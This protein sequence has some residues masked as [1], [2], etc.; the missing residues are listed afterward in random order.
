[1][2]GL[3]GPG[4]APA[5]SPPYPPTKG[6]PRPGPPPRAA[7]RGAPGGR[8]SGVARG[9][10]PAPFFHNRHT[11]Q[12]SADE[13]IRQIPLQRAGTPDDVARAI[14]FLAGEYDGF[15]SGATIDINGGIYRM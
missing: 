3:A 4:G 6:P 11:T 2:P 13:T 7:E 10:I 15:I 9:F 5:F 14:T 12:A 1:L 8:A